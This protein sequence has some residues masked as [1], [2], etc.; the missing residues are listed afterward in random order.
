MIDLHN[1]YI[2]TLL[3]NADHE[4]LAHNNQ[5]ETNHLLECSQLTPGGAVHM[6]LFVISIY[7]HVI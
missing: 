1:V 6:C 3:Y 2:Y 7:D 5:K 4:T